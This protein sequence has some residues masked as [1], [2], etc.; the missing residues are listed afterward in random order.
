[1]RSNAR[2]KIRHNVDSQIANVVISKVMEKYGW[3]IPIH[4]ALIISPAAAADVRKWYGEE[5]E[6]LYANR[7]EILKEFF[8]SIGITGASQEQWDTLQSKV[9][10]LEGELVI[11]M[12][13]K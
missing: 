8:K 6:A 4:D 1:M 11:S 2:I 12:P 13:L 7:K 3:G 5:L 9:H 10:P